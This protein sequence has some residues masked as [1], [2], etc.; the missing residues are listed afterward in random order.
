MKKVIFVL[1][2]FQIGYSVRFENLNA[3]FVNAIPKTE[4]DPNMVNALSQLQIPPETVEYYNEIATCYNAELP[5]LWNG[6]TPEER[7]FAYYMMRASIPGNIIMADQMHRDAVDLISLFHTII[8]NKEI[9]QRSC[10]G[11]MDVPQFLKEAELFLIYLFAHHGH[12][13]L[14]EF[15]DHKRSPQRLNMTELT[16]KNLALVMKA[17]NIQNADLIE[18]LLQKALFDASHEPTLVVE[19]SIEQSSGNLYAPDFTQKD[20]DEVSP[21][22]KSVLNAYFS[23]EEHDNKRV[24]KVEFYKIGGKFSRELEVAHYW[25]S[26]AHEHVLKFPN[27]FDQYIPQSLAYL[28]KYLETGDENYFKQ[29]SIA[30]LKTKSRIDFNFGFIETYHDPLHYRGSFEADITIK[31]IDM[32]KLNAM[33]PSLEKKLPFPEEFKRKNLDDAAAIPNASINAKI[34]ASGDAGPVKLTAAY[35]LP[36]YKEIRAEHGSKQIIYQAGKGLG[37]LI[38]P[39]LSRNLLNSKEHAQ[40]LEQNDPE[41]QLMRD[42]WNVQV[43]LH[44]TLGHGSGRGTMHTFVEGDPLNIGGKTYAVGDMIPVTSENTVEFFGGYSD[45]FEELRA[46][47]IALYTSIYNF[48]ELAQA[49][50]YKD[51][52]TKL[53]KQKLIE[54]IIIEMARLALSRLLSQ[55]DAA[56]E[57]VQA[58]ARADT[59]ILNYLLDHGGIELIEETYYVHDKP[60]T[61]I[62]AR[63]TDLQKTL[64]AIKKMA[65]QVQ[66]CASTADAASVNHIM[67]TYA[68]CVRYPHYIKILKENRKAVQGDLVEVAEI[69][70]RLRAVVN[71]QNMVI[72]IAAEWPKSFLEQHLE[73]YAMTYS[74]EL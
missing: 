69:F 14:K 1:S 60:H 2:F 29:F 38:N 27:Q 44:E 22:L 37:Q 30:W 68:T 20:F 73:L 25:L 51:W 5:E 7:I 31:A 15:E 18:E 34:F 35:C 17:L 41:M 23:I 12:Y 53:G 6:L 48:D 16:P 50:L 61:V 66:R 21:E 52:P 74:K 67:K 57:I 49:G 13:F 45:A 46:E 62:D 9:I 59:A 26:K 3:S 63:I 33:L 70:P 4:R 40:W 32:Q 55:S 11:H 10:T 39:I 28:L 72:D 36:N 19:G 47:I 58:H 56:L 42:I 8:T 71:N 64:D 54:C 65:C 24:P 43:I